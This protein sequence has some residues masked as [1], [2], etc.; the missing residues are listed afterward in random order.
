MSEDTRITYY[1]FSIIHGPQ[2]PILTIKASRLIGEPCKKNPDFTELR[3]RDEGLPKNPRI[4]PK[5]LKPQDC[6]LNSAVVLGAVR[7]PPPLL[8]LR[9]NLLP[10]FEGSGLW[11]LE[12]L[13]RSGFTPF[14]V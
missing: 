6:L 13:G 10:D 8:G 14:R 1:N 12:V 4:P 11:G 2:N 7:D 5:S 3:I 9:G